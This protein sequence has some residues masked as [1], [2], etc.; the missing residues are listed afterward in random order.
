M[1]SSKISTKSAAVAV[2]LFALASSG[3]A[4]VQCHLTPPVPVPQT[5]AGVYVNLVTGIS[6]ITPASAPGWDFNPWG[7]TSLNLWFWNA[8]DPS[9][10]GA[11]A[12]ATGGNILVLASGA[13]IDATRFYSDEQP[14]SA[15]NAA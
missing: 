8:A 11:V 9:S 13:T 10:A 14:A 15:E 12:A 1:P 4:A 7:G 2:S 3:K 6:G 5:T